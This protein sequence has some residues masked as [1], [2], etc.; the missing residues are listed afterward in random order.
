MVTK[1]HGGLGP[2]EGTAKGGSEHLTAEGTSDHDLHQSGYSTG[3]GALR[4]KRAFWGGIAALTELGSV[5]AVGRKAYAASDGTTM[6]AATRA[7]S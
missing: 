3:R 2:D 7:V 4:F 5:S 6:F 1:G